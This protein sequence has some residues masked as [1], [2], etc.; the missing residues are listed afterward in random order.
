M[1]LEMQVLSL[2]YIV[3]RIDGLELLLNIRTIFGP[4]N[5]LD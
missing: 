3:N 5:N 2:H 4:M 1:A